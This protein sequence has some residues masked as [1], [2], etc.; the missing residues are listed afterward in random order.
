MFLR[1]LL[2]LLATT[3]HG[4]TTSTSCTKCRRS[5][6]QL[7]G[8]H[9][10]RSDQ[11]SPSYSSHR[12]TGMMRTEA[13]ILDNTHDSEIIAAPPRPMWLVTRRAATITTTAEVEA[14]TAPAPSPQPKG[15]TT[16][17]SP[18]M[19]DLAKS[20]A[21]MNRDT[22][23][24]HAPPPMGAPVVPEP[25][26]VVAAP[27]PTGPSME[28]LARQW[29]AANR[30]V[31]AVTAP[32][33]TIPPP[34]P[35]A[36]PMM[37]IPPPPP[38]ASTT[39]EE[40]PNILN[41]DW[42]QLAADW[43]VVNRDTDSAYTAAGSFEIMPSAT[44]TTT[45]TVESSSIHPVLDQLEDSWSSIAGELEQA[46]REAA[47]T[48]AVLQQMEDEMNRMMEDL[49]SK[50][51]LYQQK[52]AQ[53]EQEAA[54]KEQHLQWQLETLEQEYL[55]FKHDARERHL[56][57]VREAEENKLRMEAKIAELRQSL[58]EKIRLVQEE[59]QQAQEYLQRLQD[60]ESKFAAAQQEHQK[61]MTR[62]VVRLKPNSARIDS[63]RELTDALRDV[64]RGSNQVMARIRQK[65]HRA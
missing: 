16:T 34:P 3:A 23:A 28:D 21:A 44:T 12:P 55:A 64:S 11:R 31:D 61:E 58:D 40:T 24:Y 42:E 5:H 41:V 2:P 60:A 4:F 8:I 17:P 63:L 43:A 27:P 46:N 39:T 65:L 22:D 52:V 36:G 26:P 1:L 20:W 48:F 15:T 6:Q 13:G 53:L 25:D 7:H 38:S 29:V 49:R 33:V 37:E 14:T 56:A 45:T 10:L 30:N 32:P 47:D 59:R 62:T 51:A 57:T 54:K 19:Q 50:E 18:T 35:P 9:V